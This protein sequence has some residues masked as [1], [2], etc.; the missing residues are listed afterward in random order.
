MA[1]SSIQE[2]ININIYRNSDVID[3][4]LT[5]D[6]LQ[7][8]EIAIL[9]RIQSEVSGKKILDIGVGGGRTIPYLLEISTQ[10]QGIDYSEKMINACK[11]KYSQV[12]LSHG[13]A[14]NLPELQNDELAM[15][16]F[17]FNG[18]DYMGHED[19]LLVLKEIYRILAPGGYFVFSSHNRNY[20][21]TGWITPN[22]FRLLL[23]VMKRMLKAWRCL[24]KKVYEI[25]AQEYVI[26]WDE[27]HG[28]LLT[29]AL[30]I[31]NQMRQLKAAGFQW[32]AM[33]VDVAGNIVEN[34]TKSPWIY[35]CVQKAL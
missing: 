12:N 26:Y 22:P 16:F 3:Q 11:K 17:S 7:P 25:H 32:P 13:D 23:R 14:R 1:I 31:E 30:S 6:S 21:D 27:A 29:Y 34:D 33:A 5:E 28:G 4:Y 9:K 15:V 24:Q 2:K 8:A 10:Y 20:R 35:Y 18:L 19:R